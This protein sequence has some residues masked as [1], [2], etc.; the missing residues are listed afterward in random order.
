MCWFCSF[1][2]HNLKLPHGKEVNC[3]WLMSRPIALGFTVCTA[4][5]LAFDTPIEK[6]TKNKCF[7]RACGYHIKCLRKWPSV[8]VSYISSP[9][10]Q[11]TQTR[12]QLTCEVASDEEETADEE[13]RLASAWASFLPPSL[14]SLLCK[15][16]Q[17][18]LRLWAHLLLLHAVHWH[19]TFHTSGTSTEAI[20]GS[21]ENITFLPTPLFR[22]LGLHLLF[23]KEAEVE[24]KK[25]FACVCWGGRFVFLEHPHTHIGI[26]SRQHS[27]L[28]PVYV[29]NIPQ[30]GV[31]AQFPPRWTLS[32]LFP[33][34]RPESKRSSLPALCGTCVCQR[35]TQIEPL[36][37]WGMPGWF[38]KSHK[39]LRRH[40]ESAGRDAGK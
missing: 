18:S 7:H 8:L 5:P 6:K 29:R 33:P 25:R 34:P 21:L 19:T 24:G 10:S 9:L 37:L 38:Q 13:H 16:I 1:W 36:L 39:S 3:T 22:R 17:F 11:I 20:K 28:L 30:M 40:C 12:V 26:A 14:A 2:L 27:P 32:I 35:L 23:V 15:A 31:R 4:E